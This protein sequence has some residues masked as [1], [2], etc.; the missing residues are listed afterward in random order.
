MDS[1]FSHK[2]DAV[3]LKRANR[4]GF[5][6]ARANPFKLGNFVAWIDIDGKHYAISQIKS[7]FTVLTKGQVMDLD[8]A[9][10]ISFLANQCGLSPSDALEALD[11]TTYK[12]VKGFK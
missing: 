12:A 5:V 4:K 9:D 11:K 8:A 7:G 1:F 2:N 3:S 10:T 6:V